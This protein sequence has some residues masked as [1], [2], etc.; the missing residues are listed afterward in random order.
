M[1]T[2]LEAPPVADEFDNA[3]H[4]EIVDGVKVELPPMSADSQF[5]ASQLAYHL[6]SFGIPRNIGS[7]T[8]EILIKLPLPVDRNRKPDVVFVPFNRWPA[9]RLPPSTNAWE[10]LPDLCVEVVSPH[11]MAEEIETKIDEYLDAGTRMVWIVYPRH[12]RVFV[13]TPGAVR[14]LTRSD[15]LEGGDVLPGFTLP[16]A[17][18]FPR[19]E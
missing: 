10:V 16:L 11:D 5:V 6:N 8:T 4:Y 2:T 15:S 1:A 17:E 19:A 7:A 18:L 13:R 9:N 14:M 12:E 3:D